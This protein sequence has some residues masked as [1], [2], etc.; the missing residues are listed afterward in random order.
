VAAHWLLHLSQHG[1]QV[2]TAEHYDAFQYIHGLI[3]GA[4]RH[5]HNTQG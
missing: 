5:S 1:R 2:Q 3:R 4:N